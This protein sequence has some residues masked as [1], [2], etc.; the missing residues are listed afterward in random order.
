MNLLWNFILFLQESWP[1][2]FDIKVKSKM[3][4]SDEKTNCP[5]IGQLALKHSL[6]TEQ[7]LNKAITACAGNKNIDDALGKYLVSKKI[8][9]DMDLKRLNTAAKAM[10]M[11]HKDIRFGVIAINLGLI[12]KNLVE[13]ALDEQKKEITIN[14]KA[15]HIGDILVEA[16]I[17]SSAQKDLILKEQNRLQ[18]EKIK[19]RD[20]D[21]ILSNGKQTTEN[22]LQ[23][24]TKAEHCEKTSD[25]TRKRSNK[26]ETEADLSC[27]KNKNI[28]I[29]FARIKKF[30]LGL[31]LIIPEDGLSAYLVKTD[32]FDKNTKVQDIFDILEKEKIT[33]GIVD[34]TLVGGFIKSKTFREKPFR[35]AKGLEPEQGKDGEIKYFFDTDRLKP[36]EIDEDGKIDFKD[37]GD[38]PY[39]KKGTILAE[40]IPMVKGKDGKNIFG[41]IIPVKPAADAKLKYDKGAFFSDNGTKIIASIDGHPNLSWA[42]VISVL[43]EFIARHDVD[44]ETGHINYKG[45]IRIKGCVKNGFKVKGNSIWANEIDGGII[46]ADGNLMVMGIINKARIYS[47]GNIRAKFIHKSK[48]L[49]LGDVNIEKEIVE[50]RIENSGACI[51]K[52][53]K[54]INSGITSKLGVYV[55][56][57]GTE[58]S[59]ASTITTGIDIFILTE[60][61]KLENKISSQKI[62]ISDS[63]K[64]KSKFERKNKENQDRITILAQIQDKARLEIKNIISKISSIDKK[65]EPQKI[66]ELKSR[67]DKL[68]RTAVEAEKKLKVYFTQTDIQD[69]KIARLNVAIALQ[70]DKLKEFI[71]EKENLIAWGKETPG[72]AMIKSSGTIMAGTIVAGKHSKKIIKNNIKNAT[73]KEIMVNNAQ[74]KN[75]SEINKQE[76]GK[77]EEA[78]SWEISVIPG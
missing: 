71:T 18:K 10:E 68:K 64:E 34:Y 50:S 67:L 44:Y 39:V 74:E 30:P 17:I 27:Q 78:L 60:T 77:Q 35:I 59:M 20:I 38:I 19:R 26:I 4:D 8:I 56:D 58:I 73:I 24:K 9:S 46:Y 51:I 70:R 23:H 43:D 6:V 13:M 55:K 45:D 25:K 12:N 5:I 33:F 36:G 21:K 16:G 14:K 57:I 1:Q 54:I 37:R 32:N 69:K 2:S 7:E 72:I 42:G 61:E 65:N 66:F 63:E 15:R 11:R 22:Q 47:R 40:K 62:N 29:N 75:T 3:P 53:G 31:K 41:K 28:D 52:K 49:C 48:V 76:E